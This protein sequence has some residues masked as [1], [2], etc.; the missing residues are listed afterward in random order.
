MEDETDDYQ[1]RAFSS[2]VNHPNIFGI[3]YLIGTGWRQS[4]AISTSLALSSTAITLQSL[5]EKIK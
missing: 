3:L 2:F 5:K 4:L 1:G